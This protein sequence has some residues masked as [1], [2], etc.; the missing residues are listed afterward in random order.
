MSQVP[1]PQYPKIRS[2]TQ[3]WC[4]MWVEVI[5]SGDRSPSSPRS[6]YLLRLNATRYDSAEQTIPT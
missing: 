2:V 1:L 6:G 5:S 3:G 4:G